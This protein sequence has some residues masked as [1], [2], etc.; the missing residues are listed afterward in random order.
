MDVTRFGPTSSN[1]YTW[2]VTFISQNGP[3]PATAAA[4]VYS[5]P[6]SSLA[7]SGTQGASCD[8][9][10]VS[11]SYSGGRRSY[12]QINS[13]TLATSFPN[14]W[15]SSGGGPCYVLYNGLTKTWELHADLASSG[16]SALVLNPPAPSPC[17][18]VYP[19]LGYSVSQTAGV[20]VTL[21]TTGATRPSLLLHGSVGSLTVVQSGV[22]PSLSNIAAFTTVG[23]GSGSDSSS[24][25]REIQSVQVT[26]TDG[27]LFGGFTLDFN[28]SGINPPVYF[29]ADEAASDFESK[30]E[31]L[32]TVGNVTVTRQVIAN[33][34][35][36]KMM[37]YNWTIEFES[38]EGDL[39]LLTY[40]TKVP[41]G[42]P[43]AGTN[44]KL[45]V[46][47]VRKGSSLPSVAYLT[48]L[49]TGTQYSVQVAAGN[50]AGQG[51][52]SVTTQG[53]GRGA[54]PLA[55]TMAGPP[56]APANLT[57]LPRSASQLEL[58]VY[59]VAAT[60]TSDTT[61]NNGGSPILSYLVEYT[62]NGTFAAS[63]VLRFRMYNRLSNDSNGYF[64]LNFHDTQ[65]T[66][67]PWGIS[68]ADMQ[69]AVNDLPSVEAVTATRTTIKAGSP[70]YSQGYIYTLTLTATAAV[71]PLSMGNVTVDTSRLTSAGPVNDFHVDILASPTTVTEPAHYNVAR[72][73]TGDCDK[74]AVGGPSSHQVVTIVTDS[75]TAVGSG[76]FKLT[77]GSPTSSQTT[78]SSTACLPFSVST[79]ALKQ[80]LQSLR[81]V[82]NVFVEE[83]K[84]NPSAVTGPYYRDLHVWFEGAPE[85][86]PAEWPL[87][88]VN[89]SV[90]NQPFASAFGSNYCSSDA[91]FPGTYVRTQ[92][93][94]DEVACAGGSPEVQTV[95]IEGK[96]GQP[97]G[98]YFY[99]YL[100][101]QQST[102]I[103]ATA[104]AVE[105]ETAVNAFATVMSG[106]GKV[107][108]TR[109]THLDTPYTG[110]AWA[111]T[112]PASYGDVEEM[113]CDDQHVTGYDVA[114]NVYPLFNMTITA[115]QSDVAGHFQIRVGSDITV[116]LSWQ[117]TDTA[118]LTALHVSITHYY[119]NMT[120]FINALPSYL[121]FTI[122][123]LA[124]PNP[125]SL[126]TEPHERGQ[127]SDAGSTRTRNLVVPSPHG[128]RH[129]HRHGRRCLVHWLHLHPPPQCHHFARGGRPCDVPCEQRC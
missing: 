29:R 51:V 67:L 106:G 38:A 32:S 117:A 110:Y 60:G 22:A 18:S 87:L 65:T 28:S 44:V 72:M 24:R 127:G 115:D 76:Q 2:S 9:D 84:R 101:G 74:L 11:D 55:F 120:Y 3:L 37:G 10:Y 105:V 33:V 58:Q 5:T 25:V 92:A 80:A 97:L 23:A 53:V 16:A 12:R 103:A 112:F 31:S 121:S 45:T 59:P 42:I 116:P 62:T 79:D 54:I 81:G 85:D 122:A 128:L 17:T 57:V 99:L 98:G 126:P 46:S 91:G 109:Y 83:H 4:G 8:G 75:T 40:S 119:P 56:A 6:I 69:A 93:I 52:S 39:P 102:A 113:A 123:P 68:G 61:A 71:G 48:G 13:L 118:V 88:R 49:T 63:R 30:I 73:Y 95:I 70:S 77:L 36:G 94:N 64:R 90:N 15:Y 96:P 66:L 107:S 82:K 7:L 50:N 26:S 21:Y 111:V 41:L 89:A 129:P 108:V 19:N 86:T 78:W 34:T 1:G 104:S 125:P 124:F 35:T 114:V 47:E 20:M 43:L 27:L 14:A 100:G